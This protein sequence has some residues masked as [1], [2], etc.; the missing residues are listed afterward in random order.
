M[1]ECF[2]E[3]VAE[4]GLVSLHVGMVGA[5]VSEQAGRE[6]VHGGMAEPNGSS[7]DEGCCCCQGCLQKGGACR[8]FAW[9]K[10][11]TNMETSCPSALPFLIPSTTSRQRRLPMNSG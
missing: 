9:A 1:E 3:H 6:G 10:R 2:S 7:G 4:G 8:A 5:I 11:L